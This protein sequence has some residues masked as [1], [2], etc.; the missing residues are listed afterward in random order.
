MLRARYRLGAATCLL[1]GQ[2]TA[3]YRASETRILGAEASAPVQLQRQRALAPMAGDGFTD[4]GE[5]GIVASLVVHELAVLLSEGLVIH[6][7]AVAHAAQRV[8]VA[9]AVTLVLL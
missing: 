9:R 1:P 2:C 4:R 5:A 6:G 3:P 8:G 7:L